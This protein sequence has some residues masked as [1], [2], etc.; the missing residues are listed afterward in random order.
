MC[1]VLFFHFHTMDEYIVQGTFD[2]FLVRPI[3]PF[4]HFM[5]IKFDVGAFGQL[6]FSIG[7]VVLAYQQL[8]LHWNWWQW[9]VFFGAIV[10]GTLIQGG[11]IVSISAVA[12]WTTR[13]ERLY[14]AIMW[15]SKNVMNYPMSIYP[16]PLQM[17]VTFVLP[18]AFV[19]YL[20]ALLLLGK[21]S[22]IFAPYWGFF[23]AVVGIV[24]FGLCLKLWMLGLDHY[25]ST[26]S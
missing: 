17:V 15:P 14:W 2:R 10:G 1:V 26:G 4:F 5:A 20:P 16:K 19:N 13:S 25:K 21:K 7:A 6:L 22:P 24:F 18:F 8:G 9:L 12:F 3:H 11:M 23:S